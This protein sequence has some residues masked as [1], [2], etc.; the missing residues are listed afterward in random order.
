MVALEGTLGPVYI[1]QALAVYRGLQ[2][3]QKKP[4][5]LHFYHIAPTEP[6]D[7]NLTL[8]LVVVVGDNNARCY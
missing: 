4:Q 8:C 3:N 6:N 7:I 5:V 1:S 2:K